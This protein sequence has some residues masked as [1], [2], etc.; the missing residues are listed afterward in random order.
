MSTTSIEIAAIRDY[1]RNTQV[2][3]YRDLPESGGTGVEFRLVYK[4]SLPTDNAGRRDRA[5]HRIRSALHPQIRELCSSHPLMKTGRYAAT[6]EGGLNY[7]DFYANQHKQVSA[8][9][10][11]Y[12]FVPI[13]T[14]HNYH[15]CSLDVLFLRRDMPG[16]LVKHGGDIDNRLKVLFDALRMPN[17]TGELDDIPQRQEETPCYCLLEDDMYIDQLSVTTDRL[18]TPMADDES[19]HDV[20]LVIHVVA[21]IS[22]EWVDIR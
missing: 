20:T 12:R 6:Y 16:W 17:G 18:L 7:W 2:W 22:S 4:G 10:H 13:I 21:R 9:D 1:E 5:K 19:I 14:S 11:I 8:G 15:G 3:R